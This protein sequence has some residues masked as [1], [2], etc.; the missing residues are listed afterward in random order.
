MQEER[1]GHDFDGSNNC[2]S[3]FLSAFATNFSDAFSGSWRSDEERHQTD[4]RTYQWPNYVNCGPIWERF[5]NSSNNSD[6]CEAMLATKKAEL[7][8]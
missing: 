8:S 5:A 7:G 1:A 2:S 3:P 6:H 4:S